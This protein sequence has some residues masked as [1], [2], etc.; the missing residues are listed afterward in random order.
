MDSEYHALQKNNT[1]ILDPHDGKETIG[2]KWIF[3]IKQ[4]SD[5]SIDRYKACLVAKGFLQE[6]SHDYFET[7]SLV[8]K[9]ITI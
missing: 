2:C 7:F 8:M 3:R 1:W 4:K 5:S 9:P 6:P